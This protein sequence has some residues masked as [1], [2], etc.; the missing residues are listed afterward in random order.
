[1][2]FSSILIMNQGIFSQKLP[3]KEKKSHMVAKLGFD[4]NQRAKKY[5]PRICSCMV[6]LSDNPV[7]CTI[8]NK[9]IDYVP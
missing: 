5:F 4:W 9:Q 8:G 7:F 6:V 2:I 3:L 1:M